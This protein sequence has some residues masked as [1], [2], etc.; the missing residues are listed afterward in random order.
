MYLQF[1][2]A[3]HLRCWKCKCCFYKGNHGEIVICISQ[4]SDLALRLVLTKVVSCL[5]R[6]F[7]VLNQF[8]QLLF[9]HTVALM[10]LYNV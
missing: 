3:T 7:L 1:A 10:C 9:E 6:L 8:F 5:L 4:K 2:S